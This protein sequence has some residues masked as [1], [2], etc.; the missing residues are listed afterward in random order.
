MN[1][2]FNFEK[3]LSESVLDHLKIMIPGIEKVAS[4]YYNNDDIAIKISSNNNTTCHFINK[5]N[6]LYDQLISLI[7]N[8][9]EFDW[10]KVDSIPYEEV[11]SSTSYNGLFE[12]LNKNILLITQNNISENKKFLFIIY[13]SQE[14]R[15]FGIINNKDS[16]SFE[17]KKIIGSLIYN[18][19]KSHTISLTQDKLLHQ[20]LKQNSDALKHKYNSLQFE[21]KQK[22]NKNN[23]NIIDICESYIKEFEENDIYKYLLSDSAKEKI[24]SYNGQISKLKSVIV[25]AAFFAG[26]TSYPLNS[27]TIII[28]EAHLNFNHNIIDNNQNQNIYENENTLDLYS[29]YNKTIELL[30]KLENASIVV[31]SKNLNLTGI[32]VGSHC[33][34]PISNAAISDALKN[35]KSKIKTLMIQ[36]PDK[37]KTIRSKFKPIIN[38]LSA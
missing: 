20:L 38:L 9:K 26:R 22:E 1:N 35:H 36:N 37:W 23:N 24:T 13:F 11:S 27:N 18:S 5:T 2:S 31:I 30:D 4:I 6:E 16:F 12:E 3:H 25:N 8:T 7:N 10:I 33:P 34:K 14:L 32:N 29:P 28:D 21:L 17:F 19:V 15:N